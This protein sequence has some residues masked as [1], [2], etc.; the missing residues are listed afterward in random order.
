SSNTLTNFLKNVPVFEINYFSL[1]NKNLQLTFTE[2]LK[3]RLL[4]DDSITVFTANSIV[5]R[6]DLLP[7]F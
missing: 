3:K 7:S 4:L 6:L 5:L 2:W 1:K